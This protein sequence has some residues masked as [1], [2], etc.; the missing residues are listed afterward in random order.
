VIAGS[1]MPPHPMDVGGV[2]DAALKFYRDRFVTLIGACAVITVP[3]AMLTVLV[4][5]DAGNAISIVVSLLLPAVTVA[6]AEQ[7][8]ETGDATI[9]S[10]WRRIRPRAAVLLATVVMVVALAAAWGLA[11]V[12]GILVLVLPGV[13]AIAVGAIF[14][15]RWVFVMMVTSV[16]DERFG[17]ALRRSS[18]LVAGHWWRVLG[19]VL[20]AGFVVDVAQFALGGA[21]GA[22]T[23]WASL[24][25]DSF[26][27][28]LA[29][30]SAPVLVLLLP[31]TASFLT[32]LYYD[33][34][35]RTEG[36]DIAAALDA[37]PLPGPGPQ[38]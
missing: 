6:V 38:P 5:T 10:T 31:L 36:L 18:A 34:R 16:E 7:V 4:S 22:I 15:V 2:F 26:N 37:I 28:L 8:I 3:A 13:I 30:A 19:I 20:L 29:I 25:E 24:S 14:V 27:R 11:V 21:I 32:M 9:G 17:D 35:V 33:Q 23:V 1:G 12:V